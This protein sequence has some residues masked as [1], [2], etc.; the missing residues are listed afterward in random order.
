MAQR[1]FIAGLLLP[2]V[3]GGLGLFFTSEDR[4]WRNFDRVMELVNAEDP[5]Q[6]AL[7]VALADEL[8]RECRQKVIPFQLTCDI[9]QR[10]YW[11]IKSIDSV[12]T[13]ARESIATEAVVAPTIDPETPADASVSDADVEKPR[14]VRAAVA[15]RAAVTTEQAESAVVA[16]AQEA[17]GK[18]SSRSLKLVE[19]LRPRIFVQIRNESDRD[20]A[21]SFMASLRE[22]ALG[23]ELD[24]EVL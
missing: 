15:S 20:A 22:K 24:L 7:G 9:N 16:A 5:D 12:R 19:S 2:T 14:A 3:I 6:Q 10:S 1:S 18:D 8:M 23:A 17:Y 13:L 21:R 4:K 11:V